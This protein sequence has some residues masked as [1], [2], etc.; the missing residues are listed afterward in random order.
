[1]TMTELF[2]AELESEAGKQSYRLVGNPATITNGQMTLRSAD[3]RFAPDQQ[4]AE[5]A[6]GGTFDGVSPDNP[7]QPIHIAW[8]GPAKITEK[9]IDVSDQA[10]VLA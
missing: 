4:L 8:A 3:I 1:M 9:G 2:L 6:A 5:I 10:A 7:N